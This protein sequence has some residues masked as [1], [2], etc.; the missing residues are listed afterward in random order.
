[1][2]RNDVKN[3]ST[4]LQFACAI[5]FILF[6]FIY[7]YF[8]QSDLLFMLQHVLSGGATR[9]DR[10]VG[11]VLITLVLYLLQIGINKITRF[12]GGLHA[13]TYVP[14]L[15]LLLM[16]TGVDTDFVSGPL[17]VTRL[18]LALLFIVT[19]VLFAVIYGVNH[20]NCSADASGS[21]LEVEQ[22][23]KNLLTLSLMFIVVCLCGNTDRVFHYRLRMERFLCSG[24]YAEALEVGEKSDDADSSLTMLRVYALSRS[25]Q[26]G[27]RLFEYPLAGGSD[28]LLPDDQNVRCLFFPESNILR[29]L[30]IRKK[31][32]MSSMQYLLYI[33]ENGLAMKSVTDYI[34]CGYLLDR[35]IDSFVRFIKGKYVLSSPALPKHYKEA[36]TLYTHLRANPILVFHNEVM[37]ADYSDFQ[38]LEKEYGNELERMSQV[39]D[40]Y[41]D[42]Y[43]FYY[44]YGE[45]KK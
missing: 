14:S 23:W 17:S 4:L 12:G 22:L 10:T 19:F 1:M 34:L 7:L 36:L 25:K 24:N 31:G 38:K 15:S 2:A 26:L 35:D 45:D 6:V 9:Y 21:S 42:T 40:V 28:A 16:L 8:F 37:D 5:V 29:N 3:N 39:R 30:S 44:F 43:W 27:D 32:V 41:G 11:A 18:V 33:E 20:K 13:L